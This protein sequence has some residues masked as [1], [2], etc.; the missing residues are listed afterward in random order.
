MHFTIRSRLVLFRVFDGC[1]SK[2]MNDFSL[3]TSNGNQIAGTFNFLIFAAAK[4]CIFLQFVV[5]KS[6]H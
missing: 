2:L 6:R 4:K 5:R 1:L 3:F